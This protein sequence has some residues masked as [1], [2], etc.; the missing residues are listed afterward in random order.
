VDFLLDIGRLRSRN[1]SA[2][3]A[4]TARDVRKDLLYDPRRGLPF[5]DNSFDA[6]YAFRIL[7][8]VDDPLALLE[9]IWRVGKAGAAVYIRVAHSSNSLNVWKDPEAGR[10]FNTQF[11]EGFEPG[12]PWEN[13]RLHARFHIDYVRLAHQ[14]VQG[15]FATRNPL[16]ILFSGV[17]EA[18]ANEDR[19]TQ[20]RAERWWGPLVGG[21]EELQLLLTVEKE[22]I[23]PFVV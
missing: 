3:R 18:L 8:T 9:E 23:D 11:F 12:S 10:G 20:Y 4:G 13:A 2:V 7:E 21:F 22:E 16:R 14:A 5:R 1:R 17:M 15:V 19:S 6:I